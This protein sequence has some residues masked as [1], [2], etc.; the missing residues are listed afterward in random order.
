MS[1]NKKGRRKRDGVFLAFDSSYEE[2]IKPFSKLD[3]KYFA[4]K[5]VSII[6]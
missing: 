6:I 5:P 2:F 3:L 4:Y 1:K